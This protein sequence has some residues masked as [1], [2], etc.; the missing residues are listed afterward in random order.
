MGI[1]I[2]CLI[3]TELQNSLQGLKFTPYETPAIPP[4]F[5]GDDRRCVEPTFNS[6]PSAVS[7]GSSG[8]D[9]VEYV[10]VSSVG[11]FVIIH[12]PLGDLV[13]FELLPFV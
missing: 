1:I 4:L 3:S 11:L 9:F 8:R 7:G 6:T 12:T 13:S 10:S 2:W 5:G